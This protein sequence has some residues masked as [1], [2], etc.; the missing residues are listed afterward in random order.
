MNQDYEDI[1]NRIKEE[2]KWFDEQAVPRYCDFA[3]R[4]CADIYA[5]EAALVLIQCQ[6]CQHQFKV[7]FTRSSMSD[8][9]HY[10][11]KRKGEPP[12]LADFIKNQT[13]HYGDPPNV[14]CCA[15]GPTMNCDDVRVLEYWHRPEFEWV[16]D[17]SLEIAVDGIK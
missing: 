3:P 9:Q 2:P 14:H 11:A 13:I 12:K 4:E 15:A 6:A 7:A 17:P 5:Q 16:R 1:R 8:V 10:I